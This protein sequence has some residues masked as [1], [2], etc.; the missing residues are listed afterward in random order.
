MRVIKTKHYEGDLLAAVPSG[1]DAIRILS[2]ALK[3]PKRKF[4]DD[5][6]LERII[7]LCNRYWIIDKDT[8]KYV[9]ILSDDIIEKE[10]A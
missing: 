4:D 1:E 8:G 5:V 3:K 6:I 9:C 10:K 7:T 2:E